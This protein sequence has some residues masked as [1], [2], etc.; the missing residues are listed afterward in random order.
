VIALP[1]LGSRVALR[2][3]L[4]PGALTDVIGFLEAVDP[5]L[6]IHTKSD[7]IV[8]VAL[9]AVVAVREISHRP[10][11]TSEIR[12][13]E[14]A[15]AM[16]WPG[17]EHQWLDGWFL[18]AG[19]G[20]TSRAN[21]A[22]PLDFSATIGPLPD[23]IEWYRR[24]DLPAWLALPERILPVRAAG[25][26]PTRVMVCDAVDGTGGAELSAAPDAN[27]LTVYERDVPV[28]VLTA[29]VDGEVAFAS[30]PGAAV[31]RGAVT[32]APDGT[33]WLGI[34]AVRVDP[35]QRRRGHARR[36]CDAL[37]NWGAQRGAQRAYVQVLADNDPAIRL[38]T[39][40]GFRLHHS[41]RYA[42]AQT[43]LG[44]GRR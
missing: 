16:A 30:I 35:E 28:D 20:A 34:S 37:Q 4:G 38:Y 22:V 29:V 6:V 10:V 1:A 7:G 32:T 33:R 12:G 2:Y 17:V 18:R 21:S 40:M 44:P 9:D 5:V 24:R 41:H 31:G 23:I 36:V 43:L 3:R 39:S 19:H 26:K 11:R 15:A 8:E 27:W 42:E 25:V 13:L 14:Q